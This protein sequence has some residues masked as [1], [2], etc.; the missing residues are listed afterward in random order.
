MFGFRAGKE[1]TMMKLVLV[2]GLLVVLLAPG[3]LLNVPANDED[4]QSLGDVVSFPVAD[5]SEKE[6]QKNLL[7]V[8][9]HAIVIM[10][11]LGLLAK[12]LKLC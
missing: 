8:A 9:V 2:V 4:S 12:P 7:R 10:L 11:V 3:V 1:K 6:W 5:A